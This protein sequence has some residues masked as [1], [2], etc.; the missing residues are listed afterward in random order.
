MGGTSLLNALIYARG[1]QID[2]D[3]WCAMGN[4]GWCYKD[5]IQHFKKSEDFHKNDPDAVAYEEYHG[6]GGP[7][8]NTYPVP[9]LQQTGVFFR[10]S[11]ELGYNQTDICGPNEMGVSPYQLNIKYGLRQDSGTAFIKPVRDRSNLKVMTGSYVTKV[12][13]NRA[14]VAEGVIFSHGGKLYKARA[15]KEVILSGGAI[16]SPQILMLSGIG[17]EKHLKQLGKTTK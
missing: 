10:A 6:R 3:R 11:Q 14:K 4:P 13:V 7:L 1:N 8:Y 17:P 16:N 9:R 12:I 15:S 2:Y 5:V